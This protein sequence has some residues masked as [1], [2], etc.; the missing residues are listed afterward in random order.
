[1]YRVNLQ[2]R[3]YVNLSLVKTY[4]DTYTPVTEGCPLQYLVEKCP[5]ILVNWSKIKCLPTNAKGIR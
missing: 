2:P 5:V 1:M 3:K 4:I